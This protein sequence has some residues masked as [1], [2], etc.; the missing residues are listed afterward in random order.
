[1]V[2]YFRDKSV[3]IFFVNQMEKGFYKRFDGWK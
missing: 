3:R 2:G 1:M